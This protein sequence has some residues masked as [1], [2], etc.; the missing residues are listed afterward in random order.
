[1]VMHVQNLS[2]N[3]YA[4]IEDVWS[5]TF[6]LVEVFNQEKKKKKRKNTAL[7]FGKDKIIPSL[8]F[9]STGLCLTK[10]KKKT[11]ASY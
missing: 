2:I 4:D 11:K 8:K 6:L 10:K 7:G 1:M 9:L 3:K 5:K